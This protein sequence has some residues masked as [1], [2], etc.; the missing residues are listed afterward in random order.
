MILS[1]RHR[2]IFLKTSKTAGTSIELA[3][4]SICGEDDICA[5]LRK[6]PEKGAREGE[7]TY[8]A[9]NHRGLFVP[10]INPDAPVT[11]LAG[12]LADL[13]NWR[14]FYNHMT[15][16]EVR[17]RAG[18]RIFDGYFKFCFERNPW[19]KTVSSYFWE[20]DRLNVPADFDAY[21]EARKLRSGYGMYTI[22]GK[23]TVDFIGRYETL[24]EDYRRAMAEIGV[25]DPPSLPRAKASFRPTDASY[26]A[27]YTP[28]SRET[29]ARRFAREID[30]LGYSF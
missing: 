2:F 1:H 20:K 9:R 4:E 21:V 23:V 10:R 29:V 18:R 24:E 26:R 7:G 17:E 8:R 5:P 25:A 11:Q 19:D 12:D 3:L 16:F 22:G 6:H 14:R 13:V 15:A 27:H 28:A 30:L